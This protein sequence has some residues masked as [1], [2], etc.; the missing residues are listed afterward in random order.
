MRNAVVE[1]PK[2]ITVVGGHV[3]FNTLTHRRAAPRGTDVQRLTGV[4][5]SSIDLHIGISDEGSS[6]VD[7]L[8]RLRACDQ[9]SCSFATAQTCNLRTR[10]HPRGRLSGRWTARSGR[11]PS[12]SKCAFDDLILARECGG[13]LGDIFEGAKF[14]HEDVDRLHVILQDHGPEVLTGRWRLSSAAGHAETP[15]RSSWERD[16]AREGV[17]PQ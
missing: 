11:G 15:G 16:L 5:S 4:S 2:I 6:P 14:L 17:V 7:L 8:V 13:S 12:G 3:Y 9:L 10:E 1:L